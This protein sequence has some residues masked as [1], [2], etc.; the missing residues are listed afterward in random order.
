MDLRSHFCFVIIAIFLGQPLSGQKEVFSSY[1][2]IKKQYENRAENDSTALPIVKQ[3]IDKARN[4]KN[5]IR[6]VEGY[7]DGIFYSA[8]SNKLK[9]ADSAVFAAQLTKDKNIIGRAHLSRG[10]VY[11]FNFKKYK[12]ALEEFLKAYEYSKKSDDKYY[13]NKVVY[14][15]AVVKSYIGYYD[16]ALILFKQTRDFFKKESEKN[17]HA[18]LQY[19]NKR[20]YYNSLHQMSICYRNLGQ[21]K[22]ADSLTLIGLSLTT[23]DHEYQQEYGYFLK[24]KG[25]SEFYKHDYISSITTLQRSKKYIANVDDFA[26]MTVCNSYIGKS[27]MALGEMK[28]A[29]PYFQK[30]D[31]VFQRHH[32]ILPEL[33]NNYEELIAHYQI[34]KNPL[35][36]LYYTKQ[37]LKADSI[38]TQD[39]PYL[40]SKIHREYD[41]RKLL[42]QKAKLE[43]KF[44]RSYM[45][46]LTLVVI[47]LL[48]LLVLY[49]KFSKER[50]IKEQYKLLEQKIL[51][52]SDLM[53]TK[54]PEK[55]KVHHKTDIDQKIVD[56]LL[57]KLKAFEDRNGFTESGLTLNKLASRFE[58][59]QTYLSAVINEY[60]GLNFN[61]Y[62]SELRIAYIT[63]KLYNDKK[64]LRYTIETLAEECGIASRNNFSDLFFEIN[65]I[66][67]SDFIKKRREDINKDNVRKEGK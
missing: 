58:K 62:L 43:T 5:Y 17:I 57:G 55:L 12:L 61:R 50:K 56:E 60:K 16:E 22:K 4:E 63:D 42:D 52:A 34:E 51:A 18:N 66:R 10:T 59:N 37:L 13:H 33:R 20:G 3:Y 65:G 30:V 36:E 45:L 40:S 54:E 27:Y 26:W 1:Y 19:G 15:L 35:K 44:S 6:L 32:F 39:F 64:Y 31:S 8:V 25:I 28:H 67:P 7:Q 47:A 53:Q 46:N 21:Q 49:I 23:G 14:R 2:L 38:I 24:E 48:L 11:Y 41:Q 9:Y 29:M